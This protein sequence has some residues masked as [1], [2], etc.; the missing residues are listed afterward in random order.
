[1]VANSDGDAYEC[2]IADQV[3][4]E[5]FVCSCLDI[6]SLSEDGQCV[7]PDRATLVGEVC[8]CPDGSAFNDNMV[9][10]C[11]NDLEV[12]S[13]GGA[14]VPVEGASCLVEDEDDDAVLCQ[15]SG[16]CGNTTPATCGYYGVDLEE[17]TPSTPGPALP[18]RTS[19]AA[20]PPRSSSASSAASSRISPRPS[21]RSAFS[22][23]RSKQHRKAG[24]AIDEQNVRS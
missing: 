20:L 3:F 9:C 16:D 5:E 13:N 7:C 19:A 4:D 15:C 8:T 23:S 22:P 10:E 12:L 14:C 11:L 6:S 24:R 1:L 18:A 21:I 2:A 17:C